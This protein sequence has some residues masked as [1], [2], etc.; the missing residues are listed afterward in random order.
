MLLRVFLGLLAAGA[1]QAPQAGLAPQPLGSPLDELKFFL[2]TGY[3]ADKF[4]SRKYSRVPTATRPDV[5]VLRMEYYPIKM[6]LVPVAPTDVDLMKMDSTLSNIKLTGGVG[7]WRGRPVPMARYEGFVQ[8]PQGPL[9][10]YGRM[11]WL[12]LHP[13]T[14]VLHLYSEPP[15]AET[16]N[17]DWDLILANIDGRIVEPTLRERAP[18]RWLASLILIWTGGLVFVVG[19][20]MVIARMNEAVG[21]QVVYLGL[22]FPAVPLVYGLLHLR[23]CWRALLVSAFGMALFGVSILLEG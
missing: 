2:P 8:G 4:L 9:G 23:E 12:P 18:G 6:P 22:L 19:I 13:G 3:E 16:M 5:V 11:V 20:I 10:V 7:T 14:I 1:L 15:W 21:G 17:R